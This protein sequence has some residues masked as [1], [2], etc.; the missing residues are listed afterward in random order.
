MHINLFVPNPLQAAKLFAFPVLYLKSLICLFLGKANL[1]GGCGESPINLLCLW[2]NHLTSLGL[3]FLIYKMSEPDYSFTYYS[4]K[5]HSFY[6]EG[7]KSG[8]LQA[9]LP[10][11]FRI[12]L[13]LMEKSSLP[14]GV[15]SRKQ[16][17]KV[18]RLS[19]SM[20]S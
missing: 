6:F 13:P 18:T 3:R 7:G 16:I 10:S 12:L 17:C 14:P 1:G 15:I 11:N 20:P 9:H 5:L 4:F 19:G 8:E 2:A